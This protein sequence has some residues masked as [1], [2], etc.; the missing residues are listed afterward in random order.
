M[1]PSE[2]DGAPKLGA[3]AS[4]VSQ[5]SP[6]HPGGDGASSPH[7]AA[8]MVWELIG[9]AIV[10]VVAVLVVTSIG[11]AIQSKSA[12][13]AEETAAAAATRSA[14]VPANVAVTT[15]K[16]ML[17]RDVI[18]LPGVLQAVD[19]VTVAAQTAG[20]IVKTA[21]TPID[22]GTYVRAGMPIIQ[23]DPRDCELAVARA[24]SA[25]DL[26]RE[27][28]ER[29]RSLATGNIQS[30]S[31]LD[32]AL[33]P[34]TDSAAAL[35]AAELDRDRCT[36]RSPIDG[37]VDRVYPKA[38]EFV[39]RGERLATIV[40]IDTVKVQVGIPERDIAAV[41]NLRSAEV[42]VKA[43]GDGRRFTGRRTY[44]ST[45]PAENTLVYLLV[46]YVDNP[47]RVLRPGMFADVEVVRAE[48]PDGIM[49]PLFAVVARGDDQY[50]FVAEP[51]GDGFVAR[52]KKVEIGIIQG[53]SVEIRAGLGAGDRLVVLGQR[54]VEDGQLVAVTRDVNDVMELFE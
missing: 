30:Q 5:P 25:H 53:R 51:A 18:H 47:S 17:V 52:R 13:L 12:H 45:R 42:V 32:A 8:A 23:I 34:F 11:A 38:G 44:L 31:A 46:L 27:N 7:R 6:E 39:D 28:L 10:V 40:N 9:L 41:T 20:P 24:K 36:V 43:A 33:A 50:A 49:A 37:F 4:T 15:L 22:E 35:A 16:P 2:D 54:S 48:R 29:A 19:E 14:A 26:A 3:A 21:S 1:H